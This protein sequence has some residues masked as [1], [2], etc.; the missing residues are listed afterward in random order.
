M[1]SS[2][3]Y[4]N[5]VTPDEELYREFLRPLCWRKLIKV[6]LKNTKSTYFSCQNL[7]FKLESQ[8]Q[9]TFLESTR[10]EPCI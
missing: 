10:T 9:T 8:N 5:C 6:I 4:V 1:F 3:Y 2:H 7:G